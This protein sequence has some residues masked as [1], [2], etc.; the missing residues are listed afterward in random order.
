MPV[1]EALGIGVCVALFVGTGVE[2]TLGVGTGVVTREGVGREEGVEEGVIGPYLH[3]LPPL[4]E[5]LTINVK[6]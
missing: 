6:S 5:Q 4:A 1:T 2:A 3:N